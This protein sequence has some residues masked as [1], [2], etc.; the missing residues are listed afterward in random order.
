[1]ESYTVESVHLISVN[2]R[3]C[4]IDRSS[5]THAAWHSP[6]HMA[7]LSSSRP[8][9]RHLFLLLLWGKA[10]GTSQHQSTI[11]NSCRQFWMLLDHS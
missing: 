7:I 8:E 1:M 11:Q 4:L 5:E 10:I 3:L 9:F 6:P 2:N